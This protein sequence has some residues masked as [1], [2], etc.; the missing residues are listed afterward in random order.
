[1]LESLRSSAG[2]VYRM[3]PRKFIPDVSLDK[4][5]FDNYRRLFFVIEAALL[6]GGKIKDTLGYKVFEM[7]ADYIIATE[8]KDTLEKN[9][10]IEQLKMVFR[11]Q[12][13]RKERGT[14]G[15]SGETVDKFGAKSKRKYLE[16]YLEET[17]EWIARGVRYSDVEEKALVGTYVRAK[18]DRP[19]MQTSK[20]T[21]KELVESWIIDDFEGIQKKIDQLQ[22]PL[23][24]RKI[25]EIRNE[26]TPEVVS[27]P[28]QIDSLCEDFIYQMQLWSFG[29]NGSMEEVKKFRESLRKQYYTQENLLKLIGE[30]LPENDRERISSS[31]NSHGK[32]DLSSLLVNA[33]SVVPLMKNC[34]TAV[35][36]LYAALLCKEIL[37]TFA[38]ATITAEGLKQQSPQIKEIDDEIRQLKGRYE[39][40]PDEL[41]KEKSFRRQLDD[42]IATLNRRRKGYLQGEINAVNFF[43]EYD[44]VDLRRKLEEIF[45]AL[46]QRVQFESLWPALMKKVSALPVFTRSGNPGWGLMRENDI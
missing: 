15:E 20:V 32:K 17:N 42:Q 5:N 35:P 10:I 23:F 9:A 27:T 44:P 18:R 12:K 39:E 13:W 7:L 33:K 40:L 41:K 16:Y 37:A 1:M 21:F 3:P 38:A 31:F 43:T 4:A 8:N 22:R 30:E 45:S 26:L 29:G 14:V 36:L 34:V 6:K 2:P 11:E 19:A 28:E 25:K 24:E 46:G